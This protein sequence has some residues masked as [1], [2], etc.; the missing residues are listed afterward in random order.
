MSDLG[1]IEFTLDGAKHVLPLD[2]A[3]GVLIEHV[4][5]KM[6]TLAERLVAEGFS[7]DQINAQLAR[8]LPT[9]QRWQEKKLAQWGALLIRRGE[10]VH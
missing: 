1:M 9:Y 3:N 2:E 4:Q 8:T 10:S 7:R 6:K 5:R